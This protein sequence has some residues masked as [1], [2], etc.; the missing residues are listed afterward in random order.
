MARP[1]PHARPLSRALSNAGIAIC[2]SL[3]P[4]AAHAHAHGAERAPSLLDRIGALHPAAVHFPIA[5]LIGAALCELLFA[6][7]EAESLRHAARVMLWMGAAGAALAAPLGWL[8]ARAHALGLDAEAAQV[9]EWH[10]WLGTATALG[11]LALLF[12]RERARLSRRTLLA[13]GVAVA[14]LVGVTG[15]LGAETAHPEAEH[16]E[17][18][19]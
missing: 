2:L 8:D 5:L 12:A 17:A 10:R 7:S 9:L 18:T 19:E 1:A 3:L 4:V 13:A 16:D 6:A 15:Y 14:L 11:A